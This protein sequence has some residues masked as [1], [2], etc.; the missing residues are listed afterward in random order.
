MRELADAGRW[1]KSVP[2]SPHKGNVVWRLK[3]G[4]QTCH[5]KSAL[6]AKN[7]GL[8]THPCVHRHW[9]NMTDSYGDAT[10]RR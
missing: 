6:R 4:R 3:T 8:Q 1:L 9:F 5:S 10:I 2:D 7:G